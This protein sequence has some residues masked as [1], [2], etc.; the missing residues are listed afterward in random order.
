[1]YL[2]ISSCDLS[3]K[4]EVLNLVN[5]ASNKSINVNSPNLLFEIK[6]LRIRNP[7]KIIIGNLNIN[8]LPNKFEQLKDI[9]MQHTDILVLTET[10]LDN[11]F[12]KAQ[13][14]VNGFSESCR[15]NRNR[16]WGG[17]MVYIR[18][19]IPSK[20][21]DKHVFPYDIEG[22]FA[23]LNFRKCKW[24]LFGTYHPSSQAD[25][26]YFEN[27]DKAFDTYSSYEKRLLIGD[28]NTE[29]SEPCIDSFIYEHDL[30]NL[31]KEKTCFKSVENPSFIDLIL[32]N[33]A[34]AFQNTTTVFTGLS[35]FHKLVLTV[36]KT[37]ITKSKPQKITYRDYKNFDSVRFNGEL[38][39]VLEKEKITSC[40]KFDEM[41]LRTLNQHAPL[42][43]KLLRA[44]HASHIS[45]PL[46]KAI[47]KRS[48]LENLYFKRR[49]DHSLRNLKKKKKS[50]C[51]RLYKKERKNFLIS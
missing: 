3:K 32:T 2:S 47:M 49:T 50:Y 19:D 25:I 33:N 24:L 39:C 37:S 13:V 10:K 40:I 36:L 15:L 18:E 21:L 5:Q 51:S 1:M 46:R 29:T 9:V 11:T 43:S 22:L 4:Y 14:L 34:M 30:Q 12:P 23:E 20:L 6:K 28:F 27:L 44:N 41:F 45:K 8:S 48:Y 31:V 17:V 42:K 7:N 35:D 26:Y 16:K 38:K